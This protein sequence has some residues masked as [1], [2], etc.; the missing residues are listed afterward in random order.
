[1]IV[2]CLVESKED[3][4]L[5]QYVL[6]SFHSVTSTKIEV[7]D[8]KDFTPHPDMIIINYGRMPLHKENVINIP[9]IHECGKLFSLGR[10]NAE[11]ISDPRI[12]N[13]PIPIHHATIS[14]LI[15]DTDTIPLFSSEERTPLIFSRNDAMKTIQFGFDFF[16]EIFLYLSHFE[17]YLREKD[18]GV[19]HPY[20][21]DILVERN[22]RLPVVNYQFALLE[23]VLLRLDTNRIRAQSEGFEV[24]FSHDLDY[25]E[26]TP[27]LRMKRL[28][29]YTQKTIKNIRQKK[30]STALKNFK[31][32]LIFF[33]KP[34]N[35]WRFGEICSLE[36]KF[37]YKSIFFVYGDAQT[38]FEKGM[39]SAIIDPEY[40]LSKN[41]KLKSTLK[42]LVKKGWKIGIH[43]SSKAYND[44]DIFFREK[45]TLE[46]TL[47]LPIIANRNHWLNFSHVTSMNV[48]ERSSIRVDSTLG[49]HD[50][51]GFR[52][53]ICSPY[54][55]YD[56]DR[57]RSYSV[58]EIPMIVMDG[59]IFDYNDDITIS[60]VIEILRE[61]K[62]FNGTVS[63]NW[64]QRTISDDYRWYEMYEQILEWIHENGGRCFL[65]NDGSTELLS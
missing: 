9:K 40:S 51:L 24:M 59:T 12:V 41:D 52:G 30:I 21:D 37:G 26:K 15:Q 19:V 64:H 58:L 39:K 8:S 20:T 46:S 57:K 31:S 14:D 6:D 36:Q 34:A 27:I 38:F 63:I 4:P 53:G 44:A 48:L 45:T 18:K 1:M 29:F 23:N 62:K 2:C 54:S 28:I 32:G 55:L 5:V 13:I 25:I 10:I 11:L 61:V 16:Y 47:G 65:P 49:Y 3:I 7:I 60:D 56:F 33:F 35:Y 42:E 22:Y 17:E 43:G 50:V